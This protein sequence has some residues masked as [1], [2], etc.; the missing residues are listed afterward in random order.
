MSST[1]ITATVSKYSVY[2]VVSGA[3]S[4]YSVYTEVSRA[5][6]VYTEQSQNIVST[7]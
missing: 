6:S 3:V 1:M 2:I 7:L 5:V 4:K